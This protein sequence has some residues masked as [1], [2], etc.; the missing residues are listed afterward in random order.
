MWKLFGG[1]NQSKRKVPFTKKYC[2]V[3]MFLYV[4]IFYKL[5]I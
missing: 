2:T 3:V 1:I 5:I 4:K